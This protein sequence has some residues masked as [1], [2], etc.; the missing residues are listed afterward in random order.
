MPAVP[1]VPAVQV[2]DKVA[3][4]P[5]FTETAGS[6]SFDWSGD[7]G[8]LIG[9]TIS[10][11]CACHSSALGQPAARHAGAA[12][13]LRLGVCL[14]PTHHSLTPILF[15]RC[16]SACLACLACLQTST[17]LALPSP[18]APWGRWLES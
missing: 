14:P 1:A 11:L 8:V 10:F 9:A 3:Y 7:V 5:K 13:W 6:L 2:P 12:S 4:L 18:S 16:P 17:S 15:G